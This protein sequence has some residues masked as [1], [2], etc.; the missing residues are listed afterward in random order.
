MAWMLDPAVREAMPHDWMKV[1]YDR[2]A[3]TRKLGD[4]LEDRYTPWDIAQ[5]KSGKAVG[6]RGALE[7]QA[8]EAGEDWEKFQTVE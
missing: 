1:A 5:I 4:A 7:Q 3:A 8:A 6:W 2:Y